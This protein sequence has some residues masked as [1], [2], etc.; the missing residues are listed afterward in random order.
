VVRQQERVE[1]VMMES[2]EDADE[3]EAEESL[4]A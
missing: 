4:G 1:T 3:D 2:G